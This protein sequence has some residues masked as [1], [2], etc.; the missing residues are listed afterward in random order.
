MNIEWRESTN[1]LFKIEK[2]IDQDNYGNRWTRKFINK[3]TAA[4]I[5]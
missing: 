1:V 4:Y 2:I 5:G 3:S